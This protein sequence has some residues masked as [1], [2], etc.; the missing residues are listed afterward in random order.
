[1]IPISF[2]PLYFVKLDIERCYDS[3]NQQRLIDII[4]EYIKVSHKLIEPFLSFKLWWTPF[5][6]NKCVSI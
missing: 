4:A 5:F 2:R 1:M 6:L 3:M